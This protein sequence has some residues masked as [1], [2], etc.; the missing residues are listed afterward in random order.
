MCSPRSI[1]KNFGRTR[2]HGTGP[3]RAE[4]IPKQK[5]QQSQQPGEGQ[6]QYRGLERPGQPFPALGD[7][8]KI[9]RVRVHE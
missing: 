4:S 3:P 2:Q 8:R 1:P 9:G 5:G 7:E 6:S